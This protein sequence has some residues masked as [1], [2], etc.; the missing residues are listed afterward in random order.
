MTPFPILASAVAAVLMTVSA[1]QAQG[2]A[3]FM[4][5]GASTPPPLG[6]IALCE[7]DLAACSSAEM[8]QGDGASIQ[9][10]AR[11]ARWERGFSDAGIGLAVP[12]STALDAKMPVRKGDARAR[13]KRQAGPFA[14]PSSSQHIAIVSGSSGADVIRLGDLERV[15]RRINRAIRQASDQAVFG[16]ADVWSIPSGAQARGDCEDYALAKRRALIA[17]GMSPDRL[18]LAIVRTRRGETHAVLLADMPDG[19]YVLDNLSP[20][21]VRWDRT[22]Y[23][24]V[25]RQV[26]GT[27]LEWARIAAV[28]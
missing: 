20:W 21:V 14:G 26:S 9:A 12:A 28:G 8:R 19:E 16:V 22:S 13:A 27:S 3:G 7:T 4:P 6:F 23:E 18:A 17:A 5:L 24:W 25:E 11:R 2:P 1:A 10:W 15:N